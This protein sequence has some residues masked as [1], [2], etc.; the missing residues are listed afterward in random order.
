[1]SLV[2]R[3]KGQELERTTTEDFVFEI[4]IATMRG[5]K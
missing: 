2:M 5:T 1:M 3:A 4:R